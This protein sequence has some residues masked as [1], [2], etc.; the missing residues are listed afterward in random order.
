M[1]VANYLDE[2]VWGEFVRRHPHGNIFHTPEMFHVFKRTEG[3]KPMIWA[4][5]D[6]GQIL[7]LLLP[8]Q[9]RLNKFF[10]SL[11]TRAVVFGSVL[12]ESGDL[13]ELALGILMDAYLKKMDEKSIFT[14]LRN[15]HDLGSAQPVLTKH[16]FVYEDH[17]NYLIDLNR[18][19]DSV[20][21]SIGKRTRKNIRRGLN[22]NLVRIVKVKDRKELDESLQLIEETYQ[23]ARVPL[24]DRSL[25]ESAYE[26]LGSKDMVRFFLA[27]VENEPVATSI[28]LLY[29]DVIYG[30]Y[31]GMNRDYSSYVPNELLMWQILKWGT[32]HGYKFYDFGGA[33]KPDEEYG[34][35]EFK[36]KFGGELVNFGR[37]IHV[38]KPGMLRLSST[39]YR[40][41]QTVKG[42]S[43]QGKHRKH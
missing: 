36:A 43:A 8:V 14:E 21:Q 32:E 26:E 34:V 27:Y 20:F 31:S 1:R 25:F 41:Y 42:I 23:R 28:E 2:G 24:A 4:V 40:V 13:G 16:G 33:G 30:W 7:A 29:K 5:V 35:R 3:Y 18:P 19:V 12:Y 22:K 11:T 9:I 17:L 15:I 37:N 10:S 6:G 39:G 38:H